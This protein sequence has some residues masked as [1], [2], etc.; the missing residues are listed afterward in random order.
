[1]T[2]HAAPAGRLS[3]RIDFPNGARLGPGKVR[4]LEEIARLGSISAAG[5]SMGMSYR[6]AW[7][8][9]DALNGMFDAPL[10]G[11]HQGGSGGGGAA[12]TPRGTEVVRLYRSIEAGAQETTAPHL[13][14]LMKLVGEV[15]LEPQQAFASLKPLTNKS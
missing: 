5:R 13:K 6:R 2:D 12:L 14:S 15:G 1:M 3:L 10:V 4:L 9:V 7:L 11:S 8:L